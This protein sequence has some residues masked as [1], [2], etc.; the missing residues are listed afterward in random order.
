MNGHGLAVGKVHLGLGF[1]VDVLGNVLAH[2]D[3][4][5]E[6]R[7]QSKVVLVEDAS[8]PRRRGHPHV[9]ARADESDREVLDIGLA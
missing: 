7:D 8:T 3:H 1:A 9:G 2:A 5:V 6:E 4:V